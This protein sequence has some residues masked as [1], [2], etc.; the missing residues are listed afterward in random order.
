MKNI[1]II[2]LAIGTLAIVPS[3]Q[4]FTDVTPKGK[5]LLLK[6][7]D[8]DA[9]LNYNFSQN[10]S[11][12]VGSAAA[13]TSAEDAFIFQDLNLLINDYYP[14]V[15]DV[16]AVVNS[17]TKTLDYVLLTS[18]ETADRSALTATDIKY[19]KYYFIINNV[20]NAVLG[21]VDQAS[22]D[23]VKA[24]QLKAEAYI[25]RAYFHYLLVNIY[26]KAYDPANAATNGGI[27]YVKEDN[28]TS[29]ANK[30]STVAEVYANILADID[31]AFQLNS[32]PQTPVNNMRVGLAFAYAVKARVLLSMRNY[33]GALSAANQ[34]L[35]IKS[36]IDDHRLYAPVGP[37][38]F[39][40]PPVTAADNLF[41][42]A[43][44][45]QGP[46]YRATTAEIN[47]NYYEP[48]NIIKQYV[49]PYYPEP[50]DI[51]GIGESNV[52]YTTTYAVNSGG[53]T[54]SD[55]YLVKAE[56]LIRSDDPTNIGAG[57]QIINDLRQR[58]IHPSVYT[59]LTATTQT[60]AMAVLKKFS[61]IEFLYTCKNF[62]N[63]KRW[64]TEDAYKETI[65]RTISGITYRLAPGSPLWIFPFPQN[66][67]SY[68]PN[69]TQNYK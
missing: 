23:R 27:P 31:A 52:W 22:G 35:S 7:T 15:Q 32:L 13:Q 50:A 17:T 33:T 43:G 14:Y 55:T 12:A 66:A 64:N 30:K 54:T 8:L 37:N 20:A 51:T 45:P 53:L 36:T 24:N 10:S 46:F 65:S 3:C 44:I 25:L 48:G 67:T 56:C 68:N 21:T 6:V 42:A 34:S 60:Q 26:A 59:A 58:R 16:N 19:S 1:I 28:I 11:V 62:L 38:P 47:N 39:S 49:V 2:L 63:I 29:E 61:R 41:Y 4:K 40:H 9:I 69:L 57:M 18:N 5:N